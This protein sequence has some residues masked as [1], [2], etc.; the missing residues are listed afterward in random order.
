MV[1]LVDLLLELGKRMEAPEELESELR[2]RLD[3]ALA[4]RLSAFSAARK[5]AFSQAVLWAVECF[6]LSAAED[7]WRQLADEASSEQVFDAAALNA[8]LE[9]FLSDNLNLSRQVQITGPSSPPDLHQFR[10]MA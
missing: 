1:A 9:R 3:P 8:V 6:T 10:R 4:D 2:E 5:V 7:A